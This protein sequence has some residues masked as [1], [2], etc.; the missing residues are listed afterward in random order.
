MTALITHALLDGLNP[1]QRA[2][3]V[4]AGK[5]LLVVAGAGSGKTRVLTRRIAYLLAARDVSPGRSSRSPSPTRPPPRCASAS[6]RWSEPRAKAMWVSTFHS[7][8]VRILRREIKRFGIS[9]TFSIYD[10]ADSQRLMTLV[11]RELDLDVKRYNP[12]AVL[13]AISTSRTS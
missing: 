9:S 13:S 4:H 5:P 11:C 6:R 2:A 7:S 1:Q 12:R 8:C 10:D 3:V